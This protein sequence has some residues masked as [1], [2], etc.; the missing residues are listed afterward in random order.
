MDDVNEAQKHDIDELL[1]ACRRA[2]EEEATLAHAEAEIEAEMERLCLIWRI[3][4]SLLSGEDEESFPK[5]VAYLM[6]LRPEYAVAAMEA[7]PRERLRLL[8]VGAWNWWLRVVPDGLKPAVECL[9]EQWEFGPRHADAI[10]TR[11]CDLLTAREYVDNHIFERI[12]RAR[13]AEVRARLER[14]RRAREAQNGTD[15]DHTGPHRPNS[16]RH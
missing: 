1:E 16:P 7:L 14:R 10:P 4:E 2:G 5:Q 15:T 8:T 13:K 11:D 3:T 9:W 6:G 12:A